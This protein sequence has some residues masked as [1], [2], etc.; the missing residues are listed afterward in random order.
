MDG[1]LLVSTQIGIK[2]TKAKTMGKGHGARN[3]RELHALMTFTV[4]V[5]RHKKDIL[6]TLPPKHRVIR[7]IDLLEYQGM[8]EAEK[9]Q[10]GET[11]HG[12]YCLVCY[13]WCIMHDAFLS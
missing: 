10:V 13:R 9:A 11:S 4:M 7:N 8:D 2:G 3:L 1:C 5:R 6:S 12:I